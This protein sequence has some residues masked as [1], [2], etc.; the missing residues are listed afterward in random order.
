MHCLV[1]VLVNIF[2]ARN[3]GNTLLCLQGD[4]GLEKICVQ[5]I[6]PELRGLSRAGCAEVDFV[7]CIL[8]VQSVVV[9]AGEATGVFFDHAVLHAPD[10]A[11]AVGGRLAIYHHG[12]ICEAG[13][14]ASLRDPRLIVRDNLVLVLF[15]PIVLAL[16]GENR[17]QT[18]DGTILLQRVFQSDVGHA[19]R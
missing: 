8:L 13:V 11:E 16:I 17:P 9:R 4:C 7:Q 5:R 10:L 6:C 1:P 14:F 15:R 19:D 2:V 12:K 18:C 3:V